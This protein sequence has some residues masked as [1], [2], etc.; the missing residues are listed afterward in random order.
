MFNLSTYNFKWYLKTC[1]IKQSFFILNIKPTGQSSSSNNASVPF[2]MRINSTTG[3][4]KWTKAFY[5]HNAPTNNQNIN[6]LDI[7]DDQTAWFLLVNAGVPNVYRLNNNGTIL[8]IIC[9]GPLNLSYAPSIVNFRI[10]SETD[11]LIIQD[12]SL[13]NGNLSVGLLTGIDVSFARISTDL[14]VQ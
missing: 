13:S 10:I 5:F 6:S 4:V 1:I 12:V 7:T 9:F 2:A 3:F 11:F 14:T 8:Q